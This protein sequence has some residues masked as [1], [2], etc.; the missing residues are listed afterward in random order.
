VTL[1]PTPEKAA[2]AWLRAAK[3]AGT[4]ETLGGG[5]WQLA[6]GPRLQ[7]LTA[8]AGWLRAGGQLVT[9]W[10]GSVQ[11]LLPPDAPQGGQ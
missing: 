10:D 1:Y 2:A 8:L 7:G 6:R 4:V 11:L 9:S 3:R 5:W